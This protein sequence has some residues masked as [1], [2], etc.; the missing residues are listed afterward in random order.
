MSARGTNGGDDEARDRAYALAA[1]ALTGARRDA[2]PPLEDLQRWHEQSLDAT[3]ARAMQDHVAACERCFELWRGL[4]ALGE[5]DPRHRPRESSALARLW[6]PVATLMRSRAL[7]AGA[8]ASVATLALI[9][10]YL[11][12]VPFGRHAPPLPGYELELQGRALF[13]GAV[14]PPL[15]A[16]V[17]FEAGTR[18]ELV[19]R[20]ERAVSE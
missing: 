13:R 6:A 9:G 20:P 11:A 16:P 14:E 3:Q 4:V 1:L 8:A 17:E 12:T 5:S 18:F 2:C 15:E 19:L 10:V 7:L